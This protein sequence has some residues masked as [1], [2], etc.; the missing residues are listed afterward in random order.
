M[1]QTKMKSMEKLLMNGILLPKLFEPTVRKNCSSD[2]EKLLKFKA[3]TIYSNSERS[4]QILKHNILLNL[5]LE[6]PIRSKYW[7][8]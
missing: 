7:N 3:G 1:F 4:E 6:V 8:K 2:W 5:L